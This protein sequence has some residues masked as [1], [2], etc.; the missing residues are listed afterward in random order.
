MDATYFDTGFVDIDPV[1]GK[2]TIAL[3]DEGD[4]KEVAV[5]EIAGGSEEL[6][7]GRRVQFL[8]EFADGHGLRK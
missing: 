3:D 5:V 2:E 7:R 4:G 8:N 1:I 6:R